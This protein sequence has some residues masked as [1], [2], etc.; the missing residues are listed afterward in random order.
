MT[1]ALSD[2]A[3]LL[4][5][6]EVAAG[7]VLIASDA[8][9]ASM[10]ADVV[11]GG[12]PSAAV[13]AAAAC[14]ATGQRAAAILASH[15]VLDALGA[16]AEAASARARLVVHV[17]PPAHAGGALTPGRDDLAPALELGAGVVVSWSAQEAVDLA[18]ALRRA[19]EDSETPFLHVVDAPPVGE[20]TVSV[21][22][23]TLVARFL[24][25][26]RPAGPPPGDGARVLRKRAERS[27]AARVPFALSGALRELGEL[28]ERPLAAVE[29]F[30]TVDAE[31][32]VV[33]L[34]S[35][36]PAAREAARA[37]RAEGRRVGA[38]GL[39]SLRPFYGAD[40]VKATARARALVCAEPLDLALAP[41]GPAASGLKAA[42]ADALTWAPGYPG[43]GRV[44]PI[45][46]AA[47]ATVEGAVR[48]RDVRAAIAEI[49]AGERA[50]RLVVFGSDAG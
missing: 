35:A 28:V 32:L 38:V 13:R 21:P 20:A 14:V 34:G 7:S 29:R 42:Y 16:V 3:R 19:A 8:T 48:E 50:R 26:P 15:E 9:A 18:I 10:G 36:F 4:V 49:G 33:A 31:E 41:C 11:A 24:G 23:P 46:C 45:V 30:E 6:V 47:F 40:V 39:R 22:A 25:A 37:L 43:V 2:V 12:S 17:V 1:T 5:Q 27:F 44:P